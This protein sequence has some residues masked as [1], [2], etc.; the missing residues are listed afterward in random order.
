MK[1]WM[2]VMAA[3][4]LTVLV[5]E[6]AGPH[7]EGEASRA[8]TIRGEVVDVLCYIAHGARGAGHRDCA[9]QCIESGLPVGILSEDGKLY[10]AVGDHAPMNKE[11]ARHAAQTVEATGKVYQR[12]G[13]NLIQID[14][15][16]VAK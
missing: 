2:A 11:L 9:Q 15:V 13:V 14:R 8:V 16:A 5:V 7:P 3:T 1:K 12:D 10:L 4:W 6:A